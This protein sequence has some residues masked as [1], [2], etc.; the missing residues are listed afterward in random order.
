VQHLH[1]PDY[2]EYHQ[3]ATIS[4]LTTRSLPT[5]SHHESPPDEQPHHQ[6]EFDEEVEWSWYSS[7]TTKD[8]AR[9]GRRD[10]GAGLHA[11]ARHV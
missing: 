11:L 2:A 7:G 8:A 5:G 1:S 6:T 9:N 10:D 4:T 3:Q